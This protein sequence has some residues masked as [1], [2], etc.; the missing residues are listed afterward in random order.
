M[1]GRAEK[2]K[3]IQ[4][5]CG[6]VPFTI[7]GCTPLLTTH[8]TSQRDDNIVA[9]DPQPRIDPKTIRPPVK[10]TARIDT[11]KYLPAELADDTYKT[12]SPV[13]I[14]IVPVETE[15]STAEI[16]ESADLWKHLRDGFQLPELENKYVRHF[17]K[18]YAKHQHLL[19]SMLQRSRRYLPYIAEQVKQRELP[20]EIALLPAVESAFKP[21]A[22]SKSRAAGLWQ[23][24]PATGKR[25]GLKQ[26]WWYDGRQDIMQSTRAALD[27]L[28][29]LEQEF[30]GDWFLALSGY[31]TGENRIHRLRRNNKKLKKPLDY[32]YL[33]LSGETRRYVPKLIALRNIIR[34]PGKY[35]I[36]LPT[37]ETDSYF[38]EVEAGAQIDLGVVAALADVSESEIRALN[39]GLKRW[40]TVPGSSHH[41]LIPASARQR[42]I[43]GL[44]GIAPDQRVVWTRHKVKQGEVLGSIARRYRIDLDTIRK[45]NKLKGDII[46]I[47]QD[48]IIPGSAV[49][50]EQVASISSESSTA[51]REA[52]KHKV[53]IGDT[54][55][56]IARRYGVRLVDLAR[57][58]RIGVSDIIK[59]EQYLTIYPKN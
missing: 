52:I 33:K 35:G 56:S 48:L 27:Y 40:A 24:V 1:Q 54:M 10:L 5:L 15:N 2:Q 13:T 3:S 39:P 46:K 17:E 42:F 22:L 29:F 57:W 21:G 49:L 12:P 34:D 36:E 38:V 7:A 51:T 44:R 55:W 8:E 23:F 20:M 45:T 16:G 14:Q 30:K 32:S 25:Y 6:L 19:L 58:N 26:T 43:A 53:S 18:S 50:A 59:P 9:Y 28:Q 41:V 4:V 37:M 47:G 11:R 31:N